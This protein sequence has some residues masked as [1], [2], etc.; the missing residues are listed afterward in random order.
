MTTS[1]SSTRS[2]PRT[3]VWL[4]HGLPLLLALSSLLIAL[5]G[6]SASVSLRY[7]RA[8]ILDGELWRL[9]S[10]HLVHLGWSHLVLNLAGLALIWGL[11]QRQLATFEWWWA[12]IASTAA[13]S[14][15]LFF[16]E[17]D[18]AWYVGLSGVL[19]GLFIAGLLLAIRRDY[20]W[21]D[22]AL[23]VIVLGKLAWEQIYGS[24]PGTTEM[25]GG[26]VVVAAHL[27]G[28]VGGALAALPLL[29]RG[30]GVRHVH[31]Q[32]E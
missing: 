24:L 18:L 8:A 22:A 30:R 10:G 17:R 4:H 32:G 16:F 3:R 6:P 12:W 23:L 20:W 29:L 25:A 15:G 26:N 7:E 2:L 11:F 19:H 21:G 1:S 14:V 13:V 27:Y 31:E 9:V 28:A 5:A